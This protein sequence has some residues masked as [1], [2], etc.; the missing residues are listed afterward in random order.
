MVDPKDALIDEKSIVLLLAARGS[1]LREL[2]HLLQSALATIVQANAS[3]PHAISS[4]A[5]P[6]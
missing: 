2:A 3:R 4:D 6:A 1:P 5:V